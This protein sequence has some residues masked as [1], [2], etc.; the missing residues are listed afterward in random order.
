MVDAD[1]KMRIENADG[2]NA[3]NK[4]SKGKKRKMWMAKK[5]KIT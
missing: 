2:K 5:K 3:D 4:K 1:G